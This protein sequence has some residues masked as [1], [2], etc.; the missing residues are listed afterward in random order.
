R[1]LYLAGQ[2][3]RRGRGV[4]AP[5]PGPDAGRGVGDRDPAVLR[6]GGLRVRVHYR[7]SGVLGEDLG[8]ARAAA[9]GGEV[10][11][12]SRIERNTAMRVMVIVKATKNSE[13]G[14]MPSGKLLAGLARL[15]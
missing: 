3:A 11:S 7:F 12:T 15:N 4:G 2:V 1:R 9:E 5:L 6:G 14:K 13:A 10:A 8:G